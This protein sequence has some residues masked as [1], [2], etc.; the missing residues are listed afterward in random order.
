VSHQLFAALDSSTIRVLSWDDRPTENCLP[1]L[2]PTVG[3]PDPT[4]SSFRDIQT[5]A[6]AAA[7]PAKFYDR[8]TEPL[9]KGPFTVDK[10]VPGKN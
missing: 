3:A 6:L 10:V 9:A 1:T 8:R 7:S 5:A 4:R 2:L